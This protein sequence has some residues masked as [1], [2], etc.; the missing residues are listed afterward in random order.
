MGH[1]RSAEKLDTFTSNLDR[2]ELENVLHDDRDF[3]VDN[4]DVPEDTRRPRK[5]YHTPEKC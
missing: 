3:A 1:L 2:A 5:R 4:N